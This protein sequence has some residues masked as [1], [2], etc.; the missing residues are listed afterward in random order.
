MMV[1]SVTIGVEQI[2]VQLAMV[3]CVVVEKE[4]LQF[5]SIRELM[6]KS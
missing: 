2:D 5:R 4:V 6:K 1:G 3:H